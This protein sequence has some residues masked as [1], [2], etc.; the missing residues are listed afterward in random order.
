VCLA[1]AAVCVAL[2]AVCVALSAVCVALS[3]AAPSRAA[4]V[5]R[6]STARQP[7][8]GEWYL[9]SWDIQSKVW[10]LSRGAGVT[11]AVIDSGVQGDFPDLKGS[12]LRGTGLDMSDVGPGLGGTPR[13]AG[14]GDVDMALH[15][16]DHGTEMAELIAGHGI[17][18]TLIDKDFAV[19]GRGLAGAGVAPEAKIL[20][21]DFLGNGR[22]LTTGSTGGIQYGVP[23]GIRYAV[24][25]GAQVISISLGLSVG[26]CDARTQQAVADAAEH[27]VVV[28]AS[29]GNEAD[30]GDPADEPAACPGVLAVGAVTPGLTSPAWTQRQPYVAVSA[31]G[32]DIPYLN[33]DGN[34]IIRGMRTD[35]VSSGTSDA[36]ALVAGAVALVRSRYPAMPAR[37]VVQRIIDTA[38]LPPHQHLPGLALGHGVVDIYRALDVSGYPVPAN[39]P[40][41]VYARLDAWLKKHPAAHAPGR[42]SASASPVALVAGA[43]VLVA[44]AVALAALLGG[45]RRKTG[46]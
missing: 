13:Y 30:R 32:T 18:S 17:V 15:S 39:A 16:G 43:V 36:A 34:I 4:P 11:V 29:A 14:P 28:V 19:V 46:S 31:P 38:V 41:P 26:G 33:T 42:H 1:L 37:E 2:A 45:R 23:A 24:G 21:I 27:N 5:T 25:H 10:P 6:A 20:P 40:N 7:P 9:D 22:A 3:A 35:S 8:W 12:V 44:G